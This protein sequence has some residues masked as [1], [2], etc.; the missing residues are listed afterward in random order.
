[1]KHFIAAVLMTFSTSLAVAQQ[2]GSGADISGSGTIPPISLTNPSPVLKEQGNGRMFI[3]VDDPL[4]DAPT[5][6]VGRDT[7]RWV[8]G[9]PIE[10]ITI[11][12][13]LRETLS[14]F[15]VGDVVELQGENTYRVMIT[16][17]NTMHIVQ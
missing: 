8:R 15:Q 5:D 11:P 2:Y 16:P 1:M 3:G 10:V 7:H 9:E 17:N 14:Q 12:E 4:P 6:N 13:S